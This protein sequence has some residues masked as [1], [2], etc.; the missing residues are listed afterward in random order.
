[1][2]HVSPR[3]ALV[4]APGAASCVGLG[5]GVPGTQL[6]TVPPLAPGAPLNSALNI[7]EDVSERQRS[8]PAGEEALPNQTG[9]T[10]N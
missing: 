5:S 7:L 6:G 9:F 1:M 4:R 3:G 2:L 8:L 10:L